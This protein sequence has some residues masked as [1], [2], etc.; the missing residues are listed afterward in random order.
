MKGSIKYKVVVD[1]NIFISF[2]IGKVLKDLPKYLHSSAVELVVSDELISELIEVTSRPKFSRY[3][4]EEIVRELLVLVEERSTTVQPISQIEACRDA[5]DNYLLALAVDGG[6]D[7]LV[8][9][10]KDLLA[11]GTFEKTRIIDYTELERTV[12][13]T[14][15]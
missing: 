11:M 6:A 2:L 7:F 8:T 5:K 10:D 14:L 4:S 13:A 1:T 12:E 9:G 3:F 15:K